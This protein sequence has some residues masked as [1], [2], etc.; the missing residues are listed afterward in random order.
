[1]VKL[2][3]SEININ[4]LLDDIAQDFVI[5]AQKQN[6]NYEYKSIDNDIYIWG[7]REKLSSVIQNLISNSFKY[8]PTEGHIKVSL[9]KKEIDRQNFVCIEIEDSGCGIDP[10]IKET[11][12][13]SYETGNNTPLFSSSIGLGLK[14]AKSITEMHHGQILV[15]SEK[16][17]GTTFFVYIPLGKEHFKTDEYCIVRTD[18]HIK[19][20]DIVPT[21]NVSEKQDS[22]TNNYKRGYTVLIIE[23]NKD[24][25]Q[26]VS[27]I[28]QK[29]Y[30]VLQ[31]EN[32]E[33]GLEMA[34]KHNP[35]IIIS[36]VMMPVM[37]GLEFCS[38][39][40]SNQQIAHIPIIMLTAK[41]EDED[42]I[43]AS[44]SGAD[45]YIRKHFNP[46]VLLSKTKHL[47]KMR[48]QLKQIYTKA[49]LNT[50]KQKTEEDT[51]TNI[52]PF[53]QQIISCIEAN[54]SNS[55]FNAKQLADIMHMSQATLYR[56]LKKHTDLTAV[57]LIRNMRMTQAALLLTNSE[58]SIV[59][60]A[61]RVGFN[62]LPTFRKH[63][64]DMFGTSPS[65]YHENHSD[66]L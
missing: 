49:L 38:Q 42:Y 48:R 40:R 27:S 32:G 60:I 22:E 45:D 7:D 56:K 18:E 41:S 21:I 58:Y 57:E 12:F 14:I 4:H 15:N 5:L 63:F 29:S 16:G 62:D 39:L 1:M 43:Q 44:E 55:D 31:A 20:T 25:R 11:I 26:Y 52:D 59:E 50:P 64:T 61:E 30:K 46:E 54:I 53:M 10:K 47:L 9:S 28:F 65:K 19:N 66:K 17:H 3:L 2:Q 34:I 36:D 51:E 37:D 23:D 13:N 6:I 8:T 24:M 35:D 33:I